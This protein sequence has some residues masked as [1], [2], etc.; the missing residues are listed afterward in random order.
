MS[1]AREEILG[2]IRTALRDVPDHEAPGDVRVERAY[3][4]GSNES[5]EA[6]V[7]R[8][9]ERVADYRAEVERVPGA[10]LG[11]AVARACERHGARRLVVPENVPAAAR[12]E[13]LDL[14]P[15]DGLTHAELDAV[16][17]V[18]TGCAVAIADTGTI[19]LDGAG[20]QGRRA[21]TLVPDLHVCIVPGSRIV[22]SVP[23][24]TARLSD[25]VT[26]QR[27]ITLISGPSATSD[28]EL[29][30]V[31]GVHGPRRL[32]VLVVE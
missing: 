17:G 12:P 32:V 21:L 31:E 7:A 30:R 16:D 2:R 10:S 11:E 22:A 26:A 15:D 24:A 6:L 18:I 25:A 29:R 27:P 8:F 13:G 28:I 23:E 20:D 5:A 1:Q 14:I 3:R 4:R 9:V 19:A